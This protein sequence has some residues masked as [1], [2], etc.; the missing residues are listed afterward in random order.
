MLYPINTVSRAVI[1]LSGVW[2]VLLETGDE[3]EISV[4]HPLKKGDSVA[5]PGS[6][7]DQLVDNEK[8]SHIGNIWY[9][10]YF[11]IPDYLS[12][13]RKVLRF[14]SVTHAASVYLNGELIGEHKGGFTP[15]EIDISDNIRSGEN[16]LTVCVSNI[17]DYTT[18]PVG[19]YTEELVDGKVTRDV[20]ENFDF[21]NYAGL[22]RPVKIYTTPKSF[23]SDLEITSSVNLRDAVLKVRSSIVGPYD[24]VNV[25]VKDER[26]NVI[27]QANGKD[28][29][30]VVKNVK[31]W[32][33]LNSYL[34]T[35]QVTVVNGSVRDVY[36]LPYGIR[37]VEVKGSQFLINNKPFYFK[38]FGKHE[39]TYLHGR[40]LNEPANVS[41][42]HIMKQMG[43]NSFRTS[44]Y[45]YS[46]EM[47]R[48]ADRE[49][50]VVIDETPAVSL[51][52]GFNVQ[53]DKDQEPNT[54]EE[55]KTFEAHEKVIKEM[56]ARDKNHACVVMWSVANEPATHHIGARE[57]FEPLVD[58]TRELDPQERPVTI[59]F[60]MEG[61]PRQE[62]THDL[63]DVICLNRYYGWYIQTGDLAAGEQALRDEL[64]EW[65]D[66]SVNKPFIFTE[67]GA[68]TVPGFHSLN[69]IPFTEEFQ[70]KLYDMYHTV[71]DD[72]NF[73]AGEQVWNFS[74]FE[75]KIG[76]G[77]VQG[78]KKGIFNR[79]REP[80]MIAYFLKKR[81][82]NIPNYN[83]KK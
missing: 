69:D 24:T 61:L 21:F 30:V 81:W 52:A 14:G 22:H 46:E 23:I 35:V 26:G 63:I 82:L 51:Y 41:D 42:I 38:G 60:N 13:E 67:Y 18:L 57:Y 48:L 53:F 72:Y 31:L 76:T 39:D 36:S 68:D 2:N 4:E 55:M 17:I 49:G 83:Y 10:R 28:A 20:S 43:A 27:S 79:A 32:E 8:R 66:M 47:M 64:N 33:P 1:D 45:P 59:V 74:D 5:V 73:I 65:I 3:G 50:I 25:L 58:L 44:H 80:K 19:V 70:V 77:R 9:E 11:S 6:F 71:F 15:F 29:E 75:T 12:S 62:L 54:W 40:G 16:R 37:S 78:N 34:Y 56:I 7:N